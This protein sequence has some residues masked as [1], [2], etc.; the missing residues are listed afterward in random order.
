MARELRMLPSVARL[1]KVPDP[2]PV[3]IPCHRPVVPQ[4]DTVK[5][6]R[7]LYCPLVDTVRTGRTLLPVRTVVH[8]FL[9]VFD[10]AFSLNSI[11]S[12][13]YFSLYLFDDSFQLGLISMVK[14]YRHIT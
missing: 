8:S 14:L 11:N 1:D 6:T 9:Y 10:C 12:T 13:F 7:Q 3:D 2:V 4:V 5:R